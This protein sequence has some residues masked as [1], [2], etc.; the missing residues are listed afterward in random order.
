MAIPTGSGTEVLKRYIKDGQNATESVAITG[1]ANHIYTILSIFVTNRDSATQ[2]FYTKLDPNASGTTIIQLK[3]SIPPDETFVCNDRFVLSGT[4][5][6]VI[7]AS[8]GDFDVIVSY[9]DQ[10]WS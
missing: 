5:K 6:L 3:P 10:D 8:G 1:V 9:I 7:D 4:D 2:T